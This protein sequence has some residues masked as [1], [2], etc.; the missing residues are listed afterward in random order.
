MTSH[1]RKHIDNTR[2]TSRRRRVIRL[3][4]YSGSHIVSNEHL[5]SSLIFYPVLRHRPFG[6]SQLKMCREV[7]QGWKYCKSDKV[8]IPSH[9]DLLTLNVNMNSAKNVKWKMES[10][11]ECESFMM[12]LNEIMCWG[13]LMI[14]EIN[15]LQRMKFLMT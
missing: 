1:H 11:T 5:Q 14:L 6:P 12:K 15:N 9:D 4:T 8:S 2:V 7:L 10:E 3:L 13:S